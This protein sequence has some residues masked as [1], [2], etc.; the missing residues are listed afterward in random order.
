M[1]PAISTTSAPIAS[2]RD[3]PSNASTD[4]ER[5]GAVAMWT[6]LSA[7]IEPGRSRS[8]RRRRTPGSRLAPLEDDLALRDIPSLFDL[9][10]GVEVA[11]P[12]DHHHAGAVFRIDVVGNGVAV[13]GRAVP[14]QDDGTLA[15]EVHRR[16][17]A[18]QVIEDRRQ[19]LSAFKHGARLAA[20]AGHV[21]LEMGVGREECLLTLRITGI[22]AVGIRV[23]QLANSQ[24]VGG[25]LR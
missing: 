16:F 7:E 24:S 25:L 19:R 10:E 18:V 21:H 14:V 22:G 17:V 9:G 4:R 6:T 2:T 23:E 20:W 3:C 8:A 15:V 5:R 11:Q 1:T 12:R 13:S